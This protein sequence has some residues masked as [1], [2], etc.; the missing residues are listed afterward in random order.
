M[1]IVGAPGRDWRT[2]PAALRASVAFGVVAALVLIAGVVSGALAV[3]V[4]AL[5]AGSLSLIFALVWRGQ[6][7][8]AW[9]TEK[10]RPTRQ[11]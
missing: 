1:A 11:W 6:L 9:R 8:E 3:L 7:I 5:T 4:V 2:W 10:G